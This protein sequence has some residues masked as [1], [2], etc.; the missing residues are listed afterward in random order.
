MVFLYVTDEHNHLVI[1]L[2]TIGVSL[3]L[4]FALTSM[5]S[6]TKDEDG[7]QGA[8]RKFNIT[9]I[10]FITFALLMAF[11]GKFISNTIFMSINQRIHK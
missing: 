11:I 4:S 10:T 5:F 2:C 7:N 3:Y 8:E 9:L 6:S 1:N